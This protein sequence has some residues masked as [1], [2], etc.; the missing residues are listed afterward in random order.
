MLKN[1]FWPRVL[2]TAEYEKYYFQQ[3][4]ARPRTTRTVKTWLKEK[5]NEKFKD[6]DMLLLLI[7]KKL[8]LVRHLEYFLKK[9]SHLKK[10]SQITVVNLFYS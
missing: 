6:K 1:I 5:F 3:D 9:V 8:L 7:R 2:R 4:G 10:L